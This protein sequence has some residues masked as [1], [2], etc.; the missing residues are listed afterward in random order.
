MSNRIRT[1]HREEAPDK[2]NDVFIVSVNSIVPVLP[3]T[4]NIFL[5]LASEFSPPTRVLYL[6]LICQA[7][8]GPLGRAHSCGRNGGLDQESQPHTT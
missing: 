6:P 4:L 2:E 8:N 5:K 3:P 1:G 7:P